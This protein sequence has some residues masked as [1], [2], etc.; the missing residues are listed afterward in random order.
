MGKDRFSNQK[1]INW[2]KGWKQTGSF[3]KPEFKKFKRPVRKTDESER[4]TFLFQC[5]QDKLSEW[6]KTFMESILS[7]DNVLTEKQNAVVQKIKNKYL[8]PIIF[9]NS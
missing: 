7:H 8:L 4:L 5:V 6:E 2:N 3:I 1:P 9:Q